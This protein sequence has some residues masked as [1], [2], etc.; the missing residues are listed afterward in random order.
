MVVFLLFLTSQSGLLGFGPR[1]TT[2]WVVGGR[3]GSSTC[4][5]GSSRCLG[6]G[7]CKR[8]APCRY[9]AELRLSGMTVITIVAVIVSQRERARESAE[10][11]QKVW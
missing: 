5:L 10:A 9:R 7:L 8:L 2:R 1:K 6:L 4:A 3:S 11:F